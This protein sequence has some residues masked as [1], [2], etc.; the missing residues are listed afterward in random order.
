M[1]FLKLWPHLQSNLHGLQTPPSSRYS[2]D[3]HAGDDLYWQLYAV[4]PGKEKHNVLCLHSPLIDL[5]GPLTTTF[6]PAPS[7]STQ[8]LGL[9]INQIYDLGGEVSGNFSTTSTTDLYYGTLCGV[10]YASVS[11][12]LPSGGRLDSYY[13]SVTSSLSGRP[14]LQGEVAY[15]SPGFICP[16]GYETV[17]TATK[18]SGGNVSSSGAAFVLPSTSPENGVLIDLFDPP[19][20]VLLEA[21]LEGEQAILCC[22]RYAFQSGKS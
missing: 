3:D 12:C 2:V 5:Q 11:G 21:M 18:S 17:A 13:N 6:T 4:Q 15:Y 14:F 10:P 1:E 19:P 9:E 8:Y 7:C 22:P 16:H 20:N